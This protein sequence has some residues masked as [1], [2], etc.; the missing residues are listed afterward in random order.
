MSRH[1]QYT[2]IANKTG[3]GWYLENTTHTTHT[4]ETSQ[5]STMTTQPTTF[6]TPYFNRFKNETYRVNWKDAD[7]DEVYPRIVS[8]GMPDMLKHLAIDV[9]NI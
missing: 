6:T 9:Q 5:T 7:E 4:T 8:F 1:K 2:S 3:A